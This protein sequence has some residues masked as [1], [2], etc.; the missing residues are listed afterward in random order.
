M[1]KS[2]KYNGLKTIHNPELLKPKKIQIQSQDEQLLKR[3][4]ELIDEQIDNSELDVKL[5]SE[6]LGVSHN[7]LYKRIKKLTGQTAKEFIRIQRIKSAAALVKEGKCSISE[8]TYLTGF[9]SP[10]YFTRCFKNY[11]G[12]TPREYYP[13]NAS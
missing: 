4:V 1:R 2:E 11:Y 10:S 12:C 3:A 7:F 8:I 6:K 13:D 9:N 5:L